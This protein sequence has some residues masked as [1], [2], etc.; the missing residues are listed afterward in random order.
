[1]VVGGGFLA[2]HAAANDA[3]GTYVLAEPDGRAHLHDKDIPTMWEQN[4][5]RGGDD[6]GRT[7]LSTL[8][9]LPVGVACGWEWARHRTMRR[10]RGRAH[11]L[12]G[13]MCWPSYPNNWR[14]LWACGARREH[15]L[16]RQHARELP[17]QVARMLGV[18]VAMPSHVGD[19]AF[20]TPL[21]PGVPWRT[22]V[23]RR[24]PDR[25]ARRPRFSRA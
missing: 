16:Q 5:Y 18:A 7:T 8:D 4:Y 20:D 13:G 23:H 10:L 11:L 19:L 14:G 24:D 2:T 6:D 15:D 3:Y 21:A 9:D 1:V 12:L 25:R 17:H 22:S